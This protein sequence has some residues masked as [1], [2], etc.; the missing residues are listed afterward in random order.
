MVSLNSCHFALHC[1]LAN[2]DA[3]YVKAPKL[4][5]PKWI[6][7]TVYMIQSYIETN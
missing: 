3:E 2:C 5:Q 1:Q 6:K 7:A 4:R